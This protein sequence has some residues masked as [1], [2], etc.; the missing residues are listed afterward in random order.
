MGVD[1][2]EMIK[3]LQELRKEASQHFGD[4]P[5]GEG[6][7]STQRPDAQGPCT[8]H[9]Q[10]VEQDGVGGQGLQWHG[11]ATRSTVMQRLAHAEVQPPLREGAAKGHRKALGAGQ[12]GGRTSCTPQSVHA[13]AAYGGAVVGMGKGW[14]RGGISSKLERLRQLQQEGES[15]LFEAGHQ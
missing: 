7:T 1:P 8:P 13:D 2:Q 14:L 6:T 15:M 3:R 12:L 5:Q 11:T 10:E 4:A 9:P